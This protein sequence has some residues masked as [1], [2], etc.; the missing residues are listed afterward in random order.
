MTTDWDLTL[1]IIFKAQKDP[2]TLSIEKRSWKSTGIK[3]EPYCILISPSE[4]IQ[5]NTKIMLIKEISK[6]D[7]SPILKELALNTLEECYQE[8]DKLEVHRW[9]TEEKTDAGT[10]SSVFSYHFLA[11]KNKS[12]IRQR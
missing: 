2:L 4:Y 5:V 9:I 6:K 1:N 7:Y 8:L 11:G 3:T 10:Y 12:N